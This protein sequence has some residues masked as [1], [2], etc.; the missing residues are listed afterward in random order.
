MF[1]INLQSVK[2][3]TREI[4]IDNFLREI[5]FSSNVT[6][7]EPLMSQQV[8]LTRKVVGSLLNYFELK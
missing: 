2:K 3:L 4:I 1:S 7:V 5:L 6:L 8:D